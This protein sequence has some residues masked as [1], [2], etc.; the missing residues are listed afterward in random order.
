M[1][2]N[3]NTRRPLKSAAI[4]LCGDDLSPVHVTELLGVV[5]TGSQAKG[6]PKGKNRTPAKVGVWYIERYS[7]D[8]R[9]CELIDELFSKFPPGTRLDNMRGV[10]NAHLDILFTYDDGQDRGTAE[11]VL[12]KEQVA[13]ASTLGL[14]VSITV[15]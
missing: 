4:Y 14:G 5:P 7:E 11:F 10:Q 3:I 6:A 13:K 8:R 2:N 12:T 9:L 1:A 15:M